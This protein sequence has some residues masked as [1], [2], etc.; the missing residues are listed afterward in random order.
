[1]KKLSFYLMIM[2]L[3]LSFLPSTALA[4]EKTNP[5]E[6][7]AEVQKMLDRLEE[8]KEIDKSSLTRVEKKELRKEVKEIKTNLRSSGNGLYLSIGAIIIIILLLILL[9]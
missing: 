5:K 7:P 6:V 8:I 3:S 9:V 1:M 2:M 4:A